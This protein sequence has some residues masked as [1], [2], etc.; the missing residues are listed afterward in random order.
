MIKILICVFLCTLCL[1]VDAKAISS[2]VGTYKKT[3]IRLSN[4]INE[5]Q[6]NTTSFVFRSRFNGFR[7][8]RHY[9]NR[10][11]SVLVIPDDSRPDSI[12]MVVWFHGLG[13]FSEKTFR[14]VLTQA[15]KVSSE[16]HSIAVAI[17]EMPWS[18]NTS[19]KRSRQGRVWEYADDLENYI[20]ENVSLINDWAA[21]T[22]DLDAGSIRIIFVGHSAGGSA[23]KSAAIEGGLCRLKP[24]AVVWSD[25]S[26]DH[27]FQKA[28]A[29]CVN[30]STTNT[31]VIVRRWDTPHRRT[32]DYIH[33][34]PPSPGR[35]H[36][37]VM[38][39]K[40]WTHGGIGDNALSIS[41]VF[42]PGC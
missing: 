10:R 16:G 42:K 8:K 23:L 32:S 11:D 35:M 40:L 21:M 15:K 31:H 18:I 28:W 22:H 5:L 17:P 29:G 1:T 39:R 3:H 7:D 36:Y 30:T 9:N 14:R 41:E 24:I 25:A 13:G 2:E 4:V 38:D 37:H 34:L 33:D 12:T 27:W 6:F 26:Y 19:T 20:N